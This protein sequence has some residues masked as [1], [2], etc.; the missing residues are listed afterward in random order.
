MVLP[1]MYTT[2][3]QYFVKRQIM[4][5]GI[6]STLTGVVSVF[7]PTFIEMLMHEY[8]FRGCM[9][10]LAALNLH[11]LLGMIALLPVDWWNKKRVAKKIE[12]LLP[13]E[14]ADELIGSDKGISVNK[15]IW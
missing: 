7:M 1:A 4:M 9:A 6:I 10:I 13:I 14:E 12:T 2:F 5:F 11:V 8:G 3:N 15:S